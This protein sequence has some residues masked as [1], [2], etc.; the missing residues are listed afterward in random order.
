MIF[1]ECLHLRWFCECRT[2]HEEH[3]NDE[4][5]DAAERSSGLCA[6]ITPAA[7][8]CGSLER[9]ATHWELYELRRRSVFGGGDQSNTILKPRYRSAESG[10]TRSTGGR[11]REDRL[12][13]PCYRDRHPAGY[14]FRASTLA[15]ATPPPV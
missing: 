5:Y 2:L 3:G 1:E 10:V 4:Q 15:L 13:E 11:Y 12:D 6:S 9:C 7:R 8:P 14:T